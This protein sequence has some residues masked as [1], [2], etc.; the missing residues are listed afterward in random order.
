ME[1]LRVTVRDVEAALPIVREVAIHTPTVRFGDSEG[2]EVWLKAENLQH[3][4]VFK[5]RGVWNRLARLSD[6]ERKR[7]VAT[8]S[9]G[10]HGLALAW[11]ARRMGVDCLVRVPE[12]AVGRKVEAIRAQGAQVVP[13]ARPDLVRAH[14]DERWRSWPQTFIHPFAHPHTIAGQGTAGWELAED[15]PEVRTILVPVGGGGLA[16][17]VAIAAKAVLP[18]AKVF[19]VQAEG[20]AALSAAL[21]TGQSSRVANPKTI[22]DGIGIGV[23]LPNMAGLLKSLLDGC[24]IVSDD[25]IRAAMRRLALEANL[26]TEPAGAAAF[27]A[28]MKGRDSLEAPVAA[29]VSG[30]N[31]D[32]GL[33][34][35]VIGKPAVG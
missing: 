11:A 5:I 24:L 1:P 17:G 27:A 30:G 33:L 15:L 4:G 28:W 12:G 10:N 3:L 8:I 9:S 35:E 14:M 23:I 19:G 32:P 31:A 29:L 20:A 7:G 16:S 18:G 6:A 21:R 13:M 34:V 2:G 26:V 25:E 22:A